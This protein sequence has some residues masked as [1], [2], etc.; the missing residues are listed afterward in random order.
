[1]LKRGGKWVETDWQTALDYVVKGLNGIKGD[2]GAEALAA[3]ASPHS[4]VEELFLI[5]QLAQAVGSLTGLPPAPVG[6]LGV[7]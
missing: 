2:H 5:K 6:F 7:G 1:M 4:T 3:L